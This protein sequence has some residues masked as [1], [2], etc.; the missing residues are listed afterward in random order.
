MTSSF[1]ISASED[2]KFRFTV[3]CV[4]EFMLPVFLSCFTYFFLLYQ[5]SVQRSQNIKDLT[6]NEKPTVDHAKPE[7]KNKT[8][9][10][11]C[12][13]NQVKVEIHIQIN[14]VEQNFVQINNINASGNMPNMQNISN[15]P[16][17]QNISNMPNISNIPN[18]QNLS[19]NQPFGQN[20]PENI[21]RERRRNVFNENDSAEN[22]WEDLDRISR[23]SESESVKVFS[24]SKSNF[25]M[26]GNLSKSKTDYRSEESEFKPNEQTVRQNSDFELKLDNQVKI[27]NYDGTKMSYY[28]KLNPISIF[29]FIFTTFCFFLS[30]LSFLLPRTRRSPNLRRS[31]P[32]DR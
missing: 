26:I 30:R 9:S 16:N 32:S 31:L 14:N 1:L 27:R 19:N 8:R 7:L 22:K 21:F 13:P 23:C 17:M 25:S 11:D 18:I 24:I 12:L 20:G 15:L 29:Y 4:A 10:D 28:K 3:V 5:K 6:D 2:S